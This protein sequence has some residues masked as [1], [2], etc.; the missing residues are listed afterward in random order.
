VKGYEQTASSGDVFLTFPGFQYRC[1]HD[2]D[3]PSD[4][5]LSV[6][7]KPA[8]VPASLSSL[9]S[10]IAARPL[11]RAPCGLASRLHRIARRDDFSISDDATLLDFAAAMLFCST[12]AR[13]H[14]HPGAGVAAEFMREHYAEPITLSQLAALASMSPFHFARSFAATHGMPPHR[15]LLRMRLLGAARRLQ[16]GGT[17][18]DAAVC[19]GFSHLSHFS[20]VFRRTFGLIPSRFRHLPL[21]ESKKLIVHSWL[22]SAES[23][24]EDL[25]S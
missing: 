2:E 8:A 24:E 13:S 16:D 25:C 7:L 9:N 11:R 19:S 21:K 3:V 5:C 12:P 14:F 22:R 18:T 20:A 10:S 6:A 1:F 4:V 17:V 15:Y 23:R